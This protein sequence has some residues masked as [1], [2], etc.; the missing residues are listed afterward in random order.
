MLGRTDQCLWQQCQHGR[1]S[2]STWD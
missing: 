1:R 2:C